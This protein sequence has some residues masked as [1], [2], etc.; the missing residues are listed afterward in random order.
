MITLDWFDQNKERIYQRLLDYNGLYSIPLSRIRLNYSGLSP[1]ESRVIRYH[2]SPEEFV[3]NF[4]K[5]K[6]ALT[7][8]HEMVHW[9]QSWSTTNC[10]LEYLY[11]N[12]QHQQLL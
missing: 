12:N 2:F 9:I 3:E 5:I 4:E 11:I 1:D 6:R 8:N 10:I 7:Y